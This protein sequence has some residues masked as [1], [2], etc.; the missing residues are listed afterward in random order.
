MNI[1]ITGGTGYFSQA[2]TK[3]LLETEV[4]NKIVIYSRGEAAQAR[5]RETM[6]SDTLRF[7]IGD[8]RDQDRLERAMQGI[9]LVIHAAALKRVEVGE[10]NPTEMV[11]T[12][13]M[14]T[15]AVIRACQQAN[16]AK[17]V[18]LSTDKACEPLNAYGATKLTAE[19]LVLAANA[20]APASTQFNVTRYGNV[21]GSTGSVIPTWRACIAQGK[22]LKITMPNA[23]RYW[24]M[25]HEACDIVWFAASSAGGKLIVPSLP[26]YEVCDLADCM[27]PRALETRITGIRP[28]E[29]LHESMI[30]GYEAAGFVRVGGYW[31]KG[32]EFDLG[33]IERRVGPMSSDNA[34]RMTKAE[35]IDQLGKLQ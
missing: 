29:K 13:V 3:F 14:G 4:A 7:L 15:M 34:R 11:Q 1:L 31:V 2:M 18:Y 24:M 21:A 32:T 35:L 16:V 17:M 23:T 27:A 6:Q 22:P 5:M 28:G 12:N 8:V 10:Y 20:E 30:S 19:K 25:P 9:D 26:A 33:A